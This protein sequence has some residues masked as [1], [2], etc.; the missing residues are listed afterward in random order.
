M[1]REV[2]MEEDLLEEIEAVSG[3]KDTRCLYKQIAILLASL[4]HDVLLNPSD[5]SIISD[6]DERKMSW[7]IALATFRIRG[8][9]GWDLSNEDLDFDTMKIQGGLY[10]HSAIVSG[11]DGGF[12]K[13]GGINKNS[14][15]RTHAVP[16]Y[17][18]DGNDQPIGYSR[19]ATSNRPFFLESPVPPMPLPP[20]MVRHF[21]ELA[22]KESPESEIPRSKL[23]IVRD[24]QMDPPEPE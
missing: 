10:R 1:I 2:L 19:V 9:K 15:I 16:P 4:G 5:P 20:I 21:A 17:Y 6:V 12:D 22:S 23:K 24:D 7:A 3:W 11:V 18:Y 8:V 13:D 14:E